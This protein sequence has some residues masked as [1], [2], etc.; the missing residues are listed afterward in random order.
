MLSTEGSIVTVWVGS[1]TSI[2][3]EN[4]RHFSAVVAVSRVRSKGK[5][6]SLKFPNVHWSVELLIQTATDLAMVSSVN[7]TSRC[8]LREASEA[9]EYNRLQL[10]LVPLWTDLVSDIYCICMVYVL[11]TSY[12]IEDILSISYNIEN[13]LYTSYKGS[14][15]GSAGKESAC[16]A[17]DLGLIPGSGRSPGGENGYPL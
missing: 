8:H 1:K 12:N 16:N 7:S 6:Y 2:S 4:R 11:S 3:G 14:P 13:I 5:M 9:E 17:G 15:C 10:F